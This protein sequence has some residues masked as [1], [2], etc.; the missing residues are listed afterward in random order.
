[1]LAREAEKVREAFSKIRVHSTASEGRDTRRSAGSVLLWRRQAARDNVC[2]PGSGMPD[3][4][5]KLVV[6]QQ[7]QPGTS[8]YLR[9]RAA[10]SRG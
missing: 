5:A 6:G 10:K 4:N 1:M 9:I 8:I 3:I 2:D 7:V